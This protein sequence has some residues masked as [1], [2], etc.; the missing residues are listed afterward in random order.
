M[1]TA[2]VNPTPETF[3]GT[4]RQQY[5]P[6]A[7]THVTIED[8]FWAPKQ[9]INRE[10]TIPHIYR[11]L[12][13]TGR[14]DAF[15][16]DWNPGPEITARGTGWG[17]TH[18]M[19]WDSD[20]AK[21]IEA[22]SFSLA[23]TPD[24]Q[25]DA[26]LDEVI[27][28]IA[29]AQHADGYLNTWF[30]TVD[31]ASRWKNLRDWHELY[32]AGHL[33]EAAVAHFQAT[34]KRS[35]LDVL[36][37]YTDY[38]GSV[39]GT[40][41]GQKR[42]YCGH[43]EIEL[44]LVKLARATGERRYMELSRYFVDQRGQKPYYF[45]QEAIER[46]ADPA[47]FWASSP[48]Y[49]QS[50]LPVREQTEAVGHAVRAV[51]LYSAMADLAGEYGDADLLAA[52]RRLWTHLTTKRMYVMGGIGTSAKNEGF[53]N[54]YDLPNESAYAETCAAIGLIF[55]AQRMLQIDLDRRYADILELALYNAVISGVSL[56]GEAFFYDNPLAS[57]GKH[58]RQGWFSCPCCP[59]N[60]ARL[61]A[62]LGDYIYAQSDSDA[63]VHLYVQGS[64]QFQ[65]GG[66]KVT[67]SQ[68]TRYPWDGAVALRVAVEQPTRFGLRLR[69]PS[70]CAAPR[71]AL[72]GTPVELAVENGYARIEREWQAGDV[73]T[74][75]LP[76]PAQ[77]VYAH[78]AIAADAGNV[79]IQRG[80][81]VYCLE[82]VD[83]DVPLDQAALLQAAEL[84]THP[85]PALLGGV[86]TL[87]GAAQALDD[88]GWAGQL[89]ST[90]APATQPSAITAIPYY[91][92]D[93]R[94]PGRMRVWVREAK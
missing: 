27:A 94:A 14:I 2:T 12:L 38:I 83:Q 59:P 45:D 93:H 88:T 92:W 21:W 58:H 4:V 23:I 51:Y 22:A 89:Y 8:S 49:N 9:A 30:T 75:D 91:A 57:D 24:P 54:D 55:W 81:L 25:L 72:N 47:K 68:E 77:R 15:R 6:L 64:G 44:A 37:R 35:L 69:L 70:W 52:C 40:G 61:L 82:Q 41:P 16:P 46:D 39:F 86:E 5:A 78:P 13:E 42:G 19:F 50:H 48:E 79:A 1:S 7:F 32:C 73:V 43:P 74:L 28:L 31:P 76:M 85:E 63:V 90:T 29:G 56:D 80:P 60:L 66:R 26:Q 65:L 33:I 36:C 10:R 17:G 84:D 34:G 11:Q 3:S 53:T 62:S 67:L 71:L 18:V 20:V 87:A